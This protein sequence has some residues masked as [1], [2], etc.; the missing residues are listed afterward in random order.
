M[1]L[2][3]NPNN[4]YHF[5]GGQGVTPFIEIPTSRSELGVAQTPIA[6]GGNTNTTGSS[7]TLPSSVLDRIN[8]AT[9][10]Q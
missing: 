8:P 10:Q 2:I 6:G 1:N 3:G 7:S 4:G 9:T 5:L